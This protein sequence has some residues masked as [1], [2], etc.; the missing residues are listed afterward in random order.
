VLNTAK[1][2]P[3]AT[4]AVFGL[5]GIGLNVVQGARMAGAHRIIGIDTNPAKRALAE[6][7]MTDFVNPK[8]VD[9]IVAAIV[10]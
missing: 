7:G 10:D 5:G 4:V 1:V 2:E 6:F 9:D 3:G 8:D